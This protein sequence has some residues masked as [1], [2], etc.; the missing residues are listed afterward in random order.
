MPVGKAVEGNYD[1]SAGC[2][3]LIKEGFFAHRFLHNIIK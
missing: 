1:R 3:I 2:S